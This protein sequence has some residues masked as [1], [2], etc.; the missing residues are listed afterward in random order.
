MYK[1]TNLQI[2]KSDFDMLT[3]FLPYNLPVILGGEPSGDLQVYLR[4]KDYNLQ[5][6]L[7]EII[8]N[9]K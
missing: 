5:L 2:S 4:A 1:F 8:N 3:L 9:K 7:L 6:T